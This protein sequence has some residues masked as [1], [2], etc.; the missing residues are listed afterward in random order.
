MSSKYRYSFLLLFIVNFYYVAQALE[1]STDFHPKGNEKLINNEG[2]TEPNA[3]ITGKNIFCK[4]SPGAEITFEG[5]GGKPPY[6]FSFQMD[7]VAQADISTTGNSDKVQIPF[8]TN[9]IKDITFKITKIKDAD[10]NEK[11]LD[12]SRL[13]SIKD[14]PVIDFTFTNDNTCSGTNVQFTSNA[15]GAGKLNYTWNFDDQTTSTLQNPSHAF[16]SLGCGIGTPQVTSTVTDANGCAA[17]ITKPIKVIQKPDIEFTDLVNPFSIF[18]NCGK[19][20]IANPEFSIEVENISKSKSCITSYSIDWGDGSSIETN[21]TFPRPHTY[22]RLGAFNLKI[23]AIGSNSCVNSITYVVKNVTNPSVGITSPGTTTNLCAPTEEL[24]FEIAKWGANSPGTIYEVDYGD[25]SPILTFTQEDL[26]KTT[27]YNSSKPSESANFPI[28]YSYKTS[29][30]PKTEFIVTVVATNACSSTTATVNNITVLTKPNP[31]FKI[32]PA[33]INSVVSLTNLTIPG[34]NPDCS[35]SG[36]YTWDFGDGSPTV[37]NTSSIPQDFTHIYKTVGSFKVTLTSE[38][39]CGKSSK[40]NQITINPLPTATM[41][42]G[43]S[44]CLNSANPEITFTGSDGK[45]PY[46]FTYK[47]NGGPNQTISSTTGNNSVKLLVPTDKAGKFI[48]TLVNVKE[49]LSGCSQNQTGTAD[50]TVNPAP[51][52]TISASQNA[53]VNGI[54]PLVTFTGSNGTAPYVFTYNING[55]PNQSISTTVGNSVTVPVPTSALGTFKYNLTGVKDASANPCSQPI[56]GSATITI[57]QPPS[58]N[59]LNDYEFCNGEK[60][61]IIEFKETIPGTTFKWT[62]SITLIGLAGSGTGNIG[63]FVAKNNTSNPIIS[64]ISVTPSVN[65]CVGNTQTFTITVN[66]ATSVIFSQNNQSICSGESSTEVTLS[67]Q[68]AGVDLSW[69]VQQPKGISEALQLTGTNTIPSQTLTNTTNAPIDL[70]YKAKATQASAN[71]CSGIEN[72]YTITIF[73]RPSIKENLNDTI[74]SGYSFNATPVQ[75]INNI[76]PTGTKYTWDEPII[77]PVGALTGTSIQTTPVSTIGQTIQNTTSSLATATYTVTPIVNNCAGEPFSVTVFVIPNTSFAPVGDITLC[78]GDFQNELVFGNNTAGVVIQWRSDNGNIGMPAQSG[79]DRI[80]AFTAINS[81]TAPEKAT[82]KVESNAEL[83]S[84]SCDVAQIKFSILVNPSAQVNNP[85]TQNVC[86]GDHI[87]IPFTTVN[88]GGTTAYEWTNSNT[89]IGLESSGTGAISFN[90]INPEDSVLTALISVTPT[91]TNNGLSCKGKTEQFLIQVNPPFIVD[92]PENQTVCSENLTSEIIFSGNTSN[93][94]YSWSINNST[95]G[96]PESGTGNIPEF[97]SF[98]DN[99]DSVVAVITVVPGLNGCVGD[100][101]TFTITVYPSSVILKQPSSSLICLGDKPTPLSVIHTSGVHKPNYQWFANSSD[102]YIGATLI[103][104][105]TNAIFMPPSDGTGNTY[106]FCEIIFPGGGG[107]NSLTSDIAKIKIN[108]NP[109]I[110][111]ND[112]KISRGQD[113]KICPD[114]Q[115]PIQVRGAETYEWTYGFLGD[116]V[117]VSRIG[118]YRVVG[119]SKVGCRDTFPFSVSYFDFWNYTI[120]SDIDEVTS[121]QTQVRFSTQDIPGSYYSWD[122]GDSSKVYGNKVEHTFNIEND[123]YVEVQLTVENPDGCIEKATKNVYVNITE[124]PNTFTPNGDGHND[125]YMQ[126]WDK[127]IFNRNGVLMFEGEDGWDGTYKGK[128]VAN[129]TYFVIIY[130]STQAGG[131]VPRTNYVTVLR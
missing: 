53:C 36:K 38:N 85:G 98:N 87:S 34:F 35:Q 113:L 55:G 31:D 19:A 115:I 61:P 81:G 127:K 7:G 1:I 107:C 4:N 118:D 25:N 66:P 93:A 76:V 130:D 102:S 62:N 51:S 60:S 18:S 29:N 92:Q 32:G 52:A 122:F 3:A 123:G 67:S 111:L 75:N 39:F 110:V 14:L 120:E 117:S 12:V 68:T 10:R 47:I 50:I 64:T 28:P 8:N 70:I 46:T 77:N 99:S 21:V 105:E 128:P 48:Y 44:V 82:I 108:P 80:P 131:S 124:I 114:E 89:N 57:N 2:L 71:A 23:T 33:C 88:T 84:S 65:S 116:S 63:S 42:G 20:S 103:P 78:S 49:D 73:P 26:V 104:N 6:T 119:I 16:T 97:T 22:K 27:Y 86:N 43:A 41:T 15:S 101:K 95:L 74:C 69:E 90:T 126:G 112:E 96:L 11:I 91:Y 58:L 30:C 24:N 79:T 72:N 100:A 17:A 37:E 125:F 129:D 5:S 83:G 109:V 9:A 13:I 121:D 54:E 106:Y 94:I 40:T 45:A 59:P 56:S